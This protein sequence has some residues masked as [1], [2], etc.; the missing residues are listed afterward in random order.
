MTGE[1]A[2]TVAYAAP[3]AEAIVPLT[4]PRGATVE[5]AV[6]A[7]GLRERFALADQAIGFAIHGQRADGDTPLA[8]GDRIELTRP[9]IA[10]AKQIRRARA[11]GK[12]LP[13]RPLR[14]KR[15]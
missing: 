6:T 3:G 12:P 14:K 11:V 1:L 4:L 9:L 8:D 5:Q 15:Q 13:K 7:S 2:I 10:D